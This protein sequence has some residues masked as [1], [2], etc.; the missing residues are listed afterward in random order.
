MAKEHSEKADPPD[1]YILWLATEIA[2]A[3]ED[4]RPNIPH[5]DVMAEM[6]AAI[7]NCWREHDL[8]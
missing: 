1:A 2:T 8:G 4:P 6:E 3:L 7:E 5:E